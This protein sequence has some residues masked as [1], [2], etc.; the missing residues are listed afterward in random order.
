MLSKIMVPSFLVCEND[1]LR[2]WSSF[3]TTPPGEGILQICVSNRWQVV[4]DDFWDCTDAIVACNKLGYIGS[5]I[6]A[7]HLI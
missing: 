5:G 3:S 6:L 2:L 7:I 4:C 1:T